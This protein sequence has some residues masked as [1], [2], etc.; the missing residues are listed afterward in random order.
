MHQLIKFL[1][2]I[3]LVISSNTSVYSAIKGALEYHIPMDY[4]K[5]SNEE[6]E[7]KA[8]FYYNLALKTSNGQVNDD[9]TA[10]LNLYMILFKKNPQNTFYVTRLG[11]LYDL[12]GKDRYAKGCFQAAIG[13]DSAQPEPYFRLGEFY[14]RRFLYKKALKMYKEAYKRGYSEHYET[15]YKIGDIYEKFGDTEA[16]LRYLKLASPKN[17]NSMLDNKIKRVEN[18]NKINQEYYSNTRIKLLEKYNN[19]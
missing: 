16:S 1:F 14:Y 4:S 19:Y 17:P 3:I 11:S 18:A 2:I 13:T 5:L 8:G 6:L 7:T 12:I 9:M 15:L 10:A